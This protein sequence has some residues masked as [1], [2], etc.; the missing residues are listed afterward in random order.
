MKKRLIGFLL[1]TPHADPTRDCAYVD[2]DDAT[3]LFFTVNSYELAERYA[4]ILALIGC[5]ALEL[6]PAFEHEGVARVQKAAGEKMPVG[7][8]RFDVYPDIP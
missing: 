1:L 5:D 3:I 6:C 4:R 8:V 2:N 7:V